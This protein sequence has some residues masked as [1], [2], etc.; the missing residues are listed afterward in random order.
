MPKYLNV[1]LGQ[2]GLLPLFAAPPAWATA[3]RSK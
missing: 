3:S 2:L 1:M